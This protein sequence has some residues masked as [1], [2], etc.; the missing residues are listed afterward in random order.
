[1]KSTKHQEEVICKDFVR[2]TL[3]RLVKFA[4]DRDLVHTGLIARLLAQETNKDFNSDEFFQYWQKH[5]AVIRK[6]LDSKWSSTAMAV[7]H[8]VF[9]KYKHKTILTYNYCAAMM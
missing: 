3:F 7:K 1:M 9:S 2:N 6:A 8:A 4:G 5:K